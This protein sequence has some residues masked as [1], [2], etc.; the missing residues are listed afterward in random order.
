MDLSNK[1]S[2]SSGNGN[3][4]NSFK[5]FLNVKFVNVNLHLKNVKLTTRKI[6]SEHKA[7]K[8]LEETKLK[9]TVQIV[10]RDLKNPSKTV[11]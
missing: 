9:E 2:F 5:H 4:K 11:K 7:F 6:T 3:D 10:N 1:Y 8:S